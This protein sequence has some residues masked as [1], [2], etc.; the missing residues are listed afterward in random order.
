MAGISKDAA[1]WRVRFQDGDG[2]TRTIRL[3]GVNKS[4]A[5]TF[6][7]HVE[8]LNAA[9]CANSTPPPSTSSWVGDLSTKLRH[10]LAAAGLVD[11]PEEPD[12]VPVEDT[13]NAGVC[14]GD[15]LA[16][17]REHGMTK[18]GRSA[19][20]LTV[21]KWRA[22]MD[23]LIR[24]FGYDRDI[25]TI[26]RDD[27]YQYRVWLGK[28]RICRTK[29]NPGGRAL[30]SNT[31]HKQVDNA[32]VFFNA[33]ESRGLI[34]SNPFRLIVSAT[35]P[36]RER[37]FFL[38]RDLT[39]RIIAECPD[40]EWRL[41]V[42]LWRYAGLRK[43]EV[44]GLKWGDVLWQSGRLRVHATKIK[45]YRNK[46][47][48]YVPTRDVQTYLED[49][50][51]AS[52]EPGQTTLPADAPI[53][54]RFSATN[55]NLDKPFKSILH[56]AGIVPWQ[57]LFQNMRASCETEML[58]TNEPH[59]VA[60]WIGHSIRVQQDHYAQV[61]DEH[62]ERYNEA[63]APGPCTAL[64]SGQHSGQQYAR[65]RANAAARQTVRSS[66]TLGFNEKSPERL[67]FPSFQIAAEGFEPPT[68]GL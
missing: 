60:A 41:L 7:T 23:R 54:T 49:V 68:R 62:F 4:T 47:I 58:R 39:E 56:R 11:L 31:I 10:K 43:M 46:G 52:L 55:S 22:P 20:K 16:E 27:A 24:F 50:F 9:R 33:A 61:T 32:K 65:T 57:K 25:T 17:H 6:K 14:L 3:S 12:P 64:K 66:K 44:F 18:R 2:N 35:E 8:H 21:E 29:A 15:F 13:D 42:A 63:A 37:D 1:G 48:R 51:Q 38:P 36:N 28:Q 40:A 59:V 45:H 26:T 30:S 19:A 34:D 5:I 53:I 67:S